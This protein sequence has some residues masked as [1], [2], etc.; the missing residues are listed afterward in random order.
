MT[1]RSVLYIEREKKKDHDEEQGLEQ[2][3]KV[4]KA[5]ETNSEVKC[6]GCVYREDRDTCNKRYKV[7]GTIIPDA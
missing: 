3:R 2:Y 4:N 5:G 6:G 7:F 1:A